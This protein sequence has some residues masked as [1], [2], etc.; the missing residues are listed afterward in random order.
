MGCC[1]PSPSFGFKRI[2]NRIRCVLACCGGKVIVRNS[3][4][5]DG[6]TLSSIYLDQSHPASFGGV[7][8]VYRELKEQGKNKISRKQVKL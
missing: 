4:F 6:E 5:C 3:E 7:D 2:F 1:P 8:A